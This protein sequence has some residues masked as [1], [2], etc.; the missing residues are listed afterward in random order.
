MALPNSTGQFA[1]DA[2]D[3]DN[4]NGV[5]WQPQGVFSYGERSSGTACYLP[6]RFAGGAPKI[7]FSLASGNAIYSGQTIRPNALSVLVLLRL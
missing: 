6:S 3:N 5:L 1:Q 4:G 2:I 7:N